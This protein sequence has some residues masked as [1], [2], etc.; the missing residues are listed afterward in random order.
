MLQ[1]KPRF[2][3][4]SVHKTA[5]SNPN[6][7][8]SRPSGVESDLVGWSNI[9]IESGGGGD[10]FLN[11]KGSE[12]FGFRMET[13]RDLKMDSFG[14]K[15]G[16]FSG[17]KVRAR[18]ELPLTSKLLVNFGWGVNFPA[19]VRKQLP[20][21][22]MDKIGIQRV[23][24]PKEVINADKV[25]DGASEV[26]KLNG[27]YSWLKRDLEELQR[28]NR[29]LR[30]SLEEIKVIGG[31]SKYST[32][33]EEKNKRSVP[34]PEVTEVSYS[35]L[36]DLKSKRNGVDDSVHNRKDVKKPMNISGSLE[37]ELQKAIKA[38]SPS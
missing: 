17:F 14:E 37:D 3:H 21:L 1:I 31:V 13:W 29:G 19:D 4:F 18:S 8:P 9:D 15:D 5:G 28:E 27:M 38:A 34:K 16:I 7:K 24:E 36:S 32:K 12:S 2:G 35:G 30:R 25:R 33:F 20:F 26:E 10:K 6:P 23:E 11:S 22:T